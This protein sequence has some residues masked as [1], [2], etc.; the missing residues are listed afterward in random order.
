M[1]RHALHLSTSYH[2]LT[3]GSHED[4]SL[5]ANLT[6]PSTRWLLLLG[7][8]AVLLATGCHQ[9]P[10]RRTQASLMRS[11]ELY[12]QNMALMQQRDGYASELA[13]IRHTHDTEKM[14]LQQSLDI[15]NQRLSNLASANGQLEQKVH[16]MLASQRSPLPDSATRELE[17]LRRRFPDFEFDP[18]TGVSKF[19]TDLLFA[20][21]SDQIRP[22]APPVLQ[23][24]SRIMNDL[25]TK[26]L[27]I[28]VVGHT[29]DEAI[30]KPA[31]R[32]KHPTNWHLSTNRANSVVLALS[33]S[34]VADTRMG[35]AGYSMFQPRSPNLSEKDRQANRRVEIFVLPADSPL[36]QNWDPAHS[37]N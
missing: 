18:I 27:R 11:Q 23:E 16:N 4:L 13:G 7:A 31:T 30:S 19:P 2:T 35:S 10:D 17:D 22:D 6:T 28:L 36:A 37:V 21:G 26:H 12:Q 15:A 34:G 9:G 29:D 32:A 14:A 5:N 25:N 3:A 1:S 20:S 24:F 8:L 33:K